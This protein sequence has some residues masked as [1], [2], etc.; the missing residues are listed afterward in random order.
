MCY[1]DSTCQVLGLLE[2]VKTV[3][4]D[5]SYADLIVMAGNVALGQ[6]ASLDLP[7]C[8]GRVDATGG[9][10]LISVLEPREYDDAI[11]G[12]RDRMKIMGLSVSQM[13]ALAGRPRS[14][15]QMIRLG[16]SGSY[17]ADPVTV[18]NTFFK[19]LL[20]ETWKE[21]RG[22]RGAE[23]EAVGNPGVYALTDDLALIWDPEFKAQA[24]K[25]AGDNDDFL[26]ELASAWTTVMNADRFDGP[27][28]NACDVHVS[29]S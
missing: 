24:I 2:P 9:D 1:P 22:S 18:S 21:V 15:S 17:T 27:T 25:F 10:E 14:P 29:L 20:K 13:V 11:V 4:P 8:S 7:F 5:I 12:V 19:I 3:Y 26:K 23:Y 6:G 16:F 28:A